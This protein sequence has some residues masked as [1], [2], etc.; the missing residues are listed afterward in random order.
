MLWHENKNQSLAIAK[1]LWGNY[2]SKS[3]I[4]WKDIKNN[5]LA[6]YFQHYKL[7]IYCWILIHWSYSNYFYIQFL[8][9]P[10]MTVSQSF[11]HYYSLKR[12]FKT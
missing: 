8:E 12:F 1:L 2:S 10:H 6:V 4:E 7:I 3:I 11:S 5:L 9:L